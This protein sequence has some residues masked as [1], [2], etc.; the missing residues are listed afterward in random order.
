VIR[1]AA[2]VPGKTVRPMDTVATLKEQRV[3]IVDSGVVCNIE[4][5]KGLDPA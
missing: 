4:R 2:K 3:T 5:A 1:K